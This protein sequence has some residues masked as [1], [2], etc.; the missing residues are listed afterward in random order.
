MKSFALFFIVLFI[1]ACLPVTIHSQG[2]TPTE[3]VATTSSTE[4]VL[5]P[6]QSTVVVPLPTSV[7]STS[8]ITAPLKHDMTNV[9]A[10]GF[11]A[12][13]IALF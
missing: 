6:D 7:T 13:V 5:L 3:I 2:E 11:V 10:A 1:I 9:A 8:V 4:T 12:A